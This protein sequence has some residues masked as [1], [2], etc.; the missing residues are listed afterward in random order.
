MTGKQGIVRDGYKVFQSSLSPKTLPNLR[1]EF[2][3]TDRVKYTFYESGWNTYMTDSAVR[4]KLHDVI[5]YK[6]ETPDL[7]A[8][9]EDF[10]VEDMSISKRNMN[11]NN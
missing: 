8:Y 9:F 10:L 5:A 11:L 2:L 4:E 6:N 1:P 7:E 3:A